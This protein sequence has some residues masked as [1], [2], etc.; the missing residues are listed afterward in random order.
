[1][2]RMQTRYPKEKFSAAKPIKRL[3]GK[4]LLKNVLDKAY[5][6][7]AINRSFIQLLPENIAQHCRVMN[8][9]KK[10]LLIEADNASIATQL[11][12]CAPELLQK[13]Q[14]KPLFAE[15]QTLKYCVRP[16]VSTIEKKTPPPTKPIS[17]DTNQLIEQTAQSIPHPELKAAL[18]RLAKTFE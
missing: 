15:I 12:Y 17:E 18:L 16:K 2:T 11:R 8:L 13:M 3:M 6:L 1:M 7:M 14:A 10:T 4:Y 9:K 5:Q